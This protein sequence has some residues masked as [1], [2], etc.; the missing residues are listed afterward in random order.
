MKYYALSILTPAH[1]VDLLPR[2]MRSV[3]E[4]TR[5]IDI[6]HLVIYTD[7][8]APFDAT[9]INRLAHAARGD[10]LC[11]LHD[12]DLLYEP[13]AA[14]MLDVASASHADVIFSDV[15]RVNGDDGHSLGTTWLLPWTLNSF[16]HTSPCWISSLVKRQRFLDVGGLPTD[17]TYADWALWYE[18]FKA[19]G[20]AAHVRTPLWRYTQHPTDHIDH[21]AARTQLFCRYPELY[22]APYE[23]A[24]AEQMGWRA[25]AHNGRGVGI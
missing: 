16:R 10:Y 11:M 7:P 12:D 25:P 20:Q 2:A 17:L 3:A 18:I 24:H 8:A 6:E 19:G 21:C 9:K 1:R 4:Q 13:F 15:E 5:R 22:D 14:E 23:A